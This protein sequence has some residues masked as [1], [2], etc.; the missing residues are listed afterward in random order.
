MPPTA[1]FVIMLIIGVICIVI[2]EVIPVD[3]SKAITWIPGV[4][5][6]KWHDRF[7][8]FLVVLLMSIATILVAGGG[9]K[10]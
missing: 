5:K 7:K 6:E 10:F 2:I 1:T 3:L 9:K 8:M 4:S